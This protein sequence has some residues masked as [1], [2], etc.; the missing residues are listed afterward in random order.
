MHLLLSLLMSLSAHAGDPTGLDPVK[1]TALVQLAA[2]KGTIFQGD[3]YDLHALSRLTPADTASTHLA[4]YFSAVGSVDPFGKFVTSKV[5]SVQE[6]WV[7]QP[8]GNWD[9][10]QWIWSSDL[11]GRLL[12][13]GHYRLQETESGSVL[14]D[15]ALPVGSPTDATEIQR[16]TKF[17]ESWE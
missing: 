6:N 16:W 1:F 10:D 12:H 13:V 17:A 7:K 14:G 8:N 9:I 4:E 3:N 11:E 15:D 2:E 5:S